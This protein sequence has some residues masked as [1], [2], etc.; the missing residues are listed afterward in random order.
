MFR[1]AFMAAAIVATASAAAAQERRIPV[2]DLLG[3]TPAEV[4]RALGVAAEPGWLP[5]AATTLDGQAVVHLQIDARTSP[6][7]PSGVRLRGEGGDSPAI[8][9][10]RDGRLLAVL[11]P[12]IIR[13]RGSALSGKKDFREAR[14]RPA[15]PLPLEAGLED[16]TA[17]LAD[18]RFAPAEAI[19]TSCYQ[20]PIYP[21]PARKPPGAADVMAAPFAL[22]Y[23]AA[24]WVAF[25][26]Y[27]AT[28][29]FAAAER[30]AAERDGPRL[31]ST[32]Q[33]GA[34]LPGGEAAFRKA[35]ARLLRWHGS[36]ATPD[37]AVFTIDLGGD[38][39]GSHDYAGVGVRGG[40]VE[41][42]APSGLPYG[43]L[44]LCQD[45]E[46]NPTTARKGCTVTG[47][48]RP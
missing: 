2:A 33:P 31:L 44:G 25:S 7:C 4:S 21:A 20:P 30:A 9:E 41:W 39:P 22:A 48:Y 26:P 24:S 1:L 5:R 13:P 11:K 42:I 14:R 6:Q 17:Q 27:L 29:P 38:R 36:D 35:N 32:L 40:V 3:K 16:W 28:R 10:F 8:F 37:Y 47:H 18:R 12:L 19:V 23:V 45:A 43:S 15:G 46:R 34:P